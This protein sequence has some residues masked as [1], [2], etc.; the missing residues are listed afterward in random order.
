MPRNSASLGKGP[1]KKRGRPRKTA[2]APPLPRKSKKP[3]QKTKPKKALPLESD[4]W[5]VEDFRDRR[6]NKKTG[7]VE[8]LIKWKGCPESSNSWEPSSNLNCLEG[9]E[10]WWKD[11][12]DRRTTKASKQDQTQES[13]ET[14]GVEKGI[15]RDEL[16]ER[17]GNENELEEISGNENSIPEFEIQRLKPAKSTKIFVEDETWEWNDAAQIKFRKVQRISVHDPS[18]RE[19]VTEARINGVPVVLIDHVGWANFALRW[20]RRKENNTETTEPQAGQSGNSKKENK[21]REDGECGKEQSTKSN[22]TIPNK[23]LGEVKSDNNKTMDKNGKQGERKVMNDEVMKSTLNKRDNQGPGNEQTE[24]LD[25]S[26]PSWCLDIDAMSTDIG[27]EVVPV[28]RKNYKESKPISGTIP[29]VKF[30]EDGWKGQE[31]ESSVSSCSKRHKSLLYLHQWQFPLSTNASKKLCHQNTPLPN[32]ILGED[33]LKYW[34][35]RVKLDSPLQYLFMG[36]ADTMSKIHKDNGGLAISIA[37]ITGEKECVL[38][39]RDDGHACLY[40]NQAALDRD[41]VD[42]NAYPLLPYARIWRTTIK[43]GEILLMPHGTYHQCRNVTPCLSYSRF[44]LDGINLRAFLHSMMDGDAPE[45]DQDMVLWNSTTEL[46]KIVD[47]A[48]DEKRKVDQNLFQAV[49]ALRTLRNTAKEVTRKLTIRE[50]VKGTNPSSDAVSSSVQIDGDAKLWQSLVDDID[51]CLHEFRYRFNSKIPPF[52]LRR[53]VGKKILALPALPFRGKAKPSE[54]EM[55]QGRKE[56]IVAFECATDRGFLALPKAPLHIL[57]E[58]REKVIDQVNS[59][60]AGDQITVRILERKCIA[61]VLGV[62][63]NARAAL[64]SFE[65]LPLLY[66]DYVP[67]DLLRIPSVGGSCLVEPIPEEVKPGRLFV[68]L[69]GK[70][71]YRGVVQHI[72]RGFFFKS[73]LDFGN[74]HFVD[75]LVD[76]DSILSV[77]KCR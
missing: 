5:E 58:E 20:L 59:I 19:L 39:H 57:P 9:A 33:L 36:K 29:A 49:D 38:V 52:K 1:S 47:N 21:T 71:E 66:D 6:K 18:A 61:T 40:N 48:T 25:L 63:Q 4:W 75:K 35:D 34:L 15:V 45:L 51:V 10:A 23:I 32:N 22:N 27:D 12:L 43:P 30:F 26:D 28:V 69:I 8:Y 44:H 24:L 72:K 16:E 77:E 68:S 7:K 37:P 50:L 64:M 46:I 70:D 74:G 62:I 3:K 55:T 60:V 67:F 56:P 73:R 11:E 65:D 14:L 41:R 76:S 2:A 31:L 17:S 54:M 42:L 13:M 53:S